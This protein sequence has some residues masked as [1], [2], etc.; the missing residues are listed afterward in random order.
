MSIT[1]TETQSE[2]Y[3]AEVELSFSTPIALELVSHDMVVSFTL[4]CTEGSRAE[5]MDWPAE[6]PEFEIDE[7]MI[8]IPD[9]PYF[10]VTDAQ[11]HVFFGDTIAAY[12][13][14]QAHDQAVESGDF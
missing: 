9:G 11:L 12:I 1:R 14:Q 7:I 6:N 10:I 13:T 4:R 3:E 2:Y 8:G 5:S